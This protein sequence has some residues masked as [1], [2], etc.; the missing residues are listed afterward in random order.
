MSTLSTRQL[1]ANPKWILAAP[2]TVFQIYSRLRNRQLQRNSAYQRNEEFHLVRFSR[3][4]WLKIQT[5]KIYTRKGSIRPFLHQLRICCR[6]CSPEVHP[7]WLEV[8]WW[9]HRLSL[10][11][12][13]IGGII[14][15]S[16][17][18]RNC[19]KKFKEKNQNFTLLFQLNI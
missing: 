11:I 6:T 2:S 10:L 8:L 13:W 7:E 9:T 14:F 4:R 16:L 18:L 17:H 3:N 5:N 1:I 15:C 19:L 12:C